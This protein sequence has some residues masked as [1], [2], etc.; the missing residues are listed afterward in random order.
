MRINLFQYIFEWF[1]KFI[2][3]GEKNICIILFNGN[4][5]RESLESDIAKSVLSKEIYLA[6]ALQDQSF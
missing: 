1:H 5:N 4:K 2:G 6:T 3:I